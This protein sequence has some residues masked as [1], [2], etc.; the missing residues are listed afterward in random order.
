MLKQCLFFIRN[1]DLN[2]IKYYGGFTVYNDI[3][4]P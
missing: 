2:I 3:K 4:I 1:I